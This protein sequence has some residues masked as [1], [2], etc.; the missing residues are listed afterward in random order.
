MGNLARISYAYVLFARPP[1]RTQYRRGHVDAGAFVPTSMASPAA[2]GG[3]S[4]APRCALMYRKNWLP[5]VRG[6]RSRSELAACNAL[7]RKQASKATY[8]MTYATANGGIYMR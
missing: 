3:P 7:A 2:R 5:G 4:S 6:F 1:A 8:L